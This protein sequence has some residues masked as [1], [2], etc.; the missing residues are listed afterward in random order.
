M[1]TKVLT[2]LGECESIIS[3]V[4]NVIHLTDT[5]D[6]VTN[7]LQTEEFETIR[8][9]VEEMQD[10]VLHFY[11][12]SD[13][14]ITDPEYVE[15]SIRLYQECKYIVEALEDSIQD[16]EVLKEFSYIRSAVNFIRQLG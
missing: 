8:Y 10:F 12:D 11:E 15:L 7:L 6:F 1:T 5:N 13:E 14:F 9:T 3:C 2:F 16:S 4:E